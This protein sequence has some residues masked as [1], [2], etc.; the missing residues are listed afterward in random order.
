MGGWVD[1]CG[2]VSGCVAGRIPAG[3]K[4]SAGW[5]GLSN[6]RVSRWAI[7]KMDE[8]DSFLLCNVCVCVCVCVCVD[9]YLLR[10]GAGEGAEGV[11]GE[12]EGGLAR[13][14]RLG[15]LGLR[16]RVSTTMD[17]ADGVRYAS[18]YGG[19]SFI[20]VAL[21]AAPPTP[22]SSP[23]WPPPPPGHLLLATDYSPQTE[24]SRQ[25]S[26]KL[27]FRGVVA[28]RSHATASAAWRLPPQPV[29]ISPLH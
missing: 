8:R 9:E 12:E 11:K 18:N 23:S 17:G 24:L 29:A 28:S 22:S 20:F 19:G 27:I 3:L 1:G 10:G 13:R 6:G 16:G 2:P 26:S 14:M 15:L 5:M 7:D 4:P 25:A 21:P